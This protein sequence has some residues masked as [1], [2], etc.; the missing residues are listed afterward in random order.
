MFNRNFILAA[1]VIG[2]AIS[3]QPLRGEMPITISA[4][5]TKIT[6]GDTFKV[7]YAGVGIPDT[8]RV[9]GIDCPESKANKKCKR[10]G[11]TAC[12][13][14][15]PKG[16]KATER[17]KTLL[18]GQTIVLEPPGKFERDQN[19]RLL[20]YVRLKDGRDFGL[21]LIREGLCRDFGF[22]YPHPRAAEYRKAEKE[23]AKK[24]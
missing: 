18:D 8:I 23:A 20:S 9:K 14:Q 3:A 22:R 19:N 10:D 16:K 6:D 4:K 12:S 1:V 11:E 7:E 15:I 24:K 5:V 17:A 2:F 21:V 13:L